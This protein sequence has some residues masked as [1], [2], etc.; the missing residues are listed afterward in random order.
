MNTVKRN[1]HKW[2]TVPPGWKSRWYQTISLTLTLAVVVMLAN[3]ALPQP[4]SASSA[5]TN[6]GA[7]LLQFT[8]AGQVLGFSDDS[9]IVASTS[10]ML[11][12]DFLNSNVITPKADNAASGESITGKASAL[13]S[14]TYQ[15]LWDGVTV[16][17]EA[18]GT[19]IAKSTYY[20]E[21]ESQVDSIRLGY[22]HPV[23]IDKNGNLS[24]DY[25]DGTIVE[26]TPVAWQEIDGKKKPVTAS[27]VL[28]GE[29]E[30]GFSLADYVPGIAM[31]IDP[32][33]SWNTF[34]GGSGEGDCDDNG[35]AIA[36][37]SS[38]NVYVAGYS[39]ESW[40]TPVRAFSGGSYD[41]F[42]A[43]L[44][45]SGNLLWNTFLGSNGAD[46]VFSIAVDS[47]GS[48]VYA[49]GESNATWGLP[50]RS[51]TTEGSHDED[52]FAAKLNAGNGSLSWNTFLGV[53]VALADYNGEYDMVQYFCGIAL[54][55]SGNVYISGNSDATWQGSSPPVRAYISGDGEDIFAAK[56]DSSGSLQ[57]NT[58]LGGTGTDRSSTIAID[59]SGNVYVAGNSDA[60]WGSPM[61]V[62]SDGTDVFAAKLN[63][64]GVLQWNTFLGSGS[65]WSG[66]IAV[67]GSGNIYVCGESDAAWGSP[68]LPF[69][70]DGYDET[71]VAQLSNSGTLTWN[72]FLGSG[73][74]GYASGIALDSSGN[75]YICGDTTATWGS[76]TRAFTTGTDENAGS[77]NAFAAKL[78]S[79]GSLI[80]NTFL[81]GGSL[82]FGSGI[83]ID[84]SGGHVYVAGSTGAEWAMD[85]DYSADATWGS[86]VRAYTP[87]PYMQ[88]WSWD[89][90]AARVDSSGALTWNTFLGGPAIGNSNDDG[91]AIV[92]DSSGNV[93]VTGDSQASWGSPVRAYTSCGGVYDPADEG[94]DAFVAKLDSSG[95]LLWN[96]FLGGSGADHSQAIVLDGS[97]NIY[98]SGESN[99]TWGSPLRDYTPPT[100]TPDVGQTPV[101]DAFV[102]S[103]NSNGVLQWN[104]FLGGSGW[105]EGNAIALDSSGNIYVA[106]NSTATWQGSS[107]P[108]YAYSGSGSPAPD[109]AFVAKL[110]S[111]GNLTWNTFIPGDNSNGYLPGSISYA[112]AVDGSG[113][114][115]YIAGSSGAWGSPVRAYGGGGSDVFVAKLSG[116]NGART[117]NTFLGGTAADLCY[118]GIAVDGSGNIYVG[119][120]SNVTWGSPVRAFTTNNY[121][122]DAFVAKLS[123]SG[124]LTWNTFLGGSDSDQLSALVLDGSGNN[125]YAVGTSRATWGSPVQP[126]T[127]GPG[128][129]AKLNS[130]SGDLTWNTFPGGSDVHG[131]ALDSS[132]NIYITGTSYATWGTP[133][134]AFTTGSDAYVAKLDYH[135]PPTA[136]ITYS[137]TGPVKAGTSLTI[138]ATFSSAMGDNPVPQIAISGNN[139]LTATA[140]TKTDSTHYIYTYTVGTGDGTDT[141]ALSTGTDLAGNVVT[142]APTSGAN[143]TVDNTPPTAAITYSPNHSVNAGTSLLITA[144]FSQAMGDS[145]VPQIAISGNNTLTATAMTKT[146]ST[147]YTY[148]YTVGT[149]DGTDT[150]A[151]STGTDLANNVVTS[152]PTSGANFTVD[153]TPPAAAITYSLNHPVNAGTS[154]LITATFS[155][156]MGDSPVPQI[157][158]S[159]NN[160]LTATAMTKTDSTHYTYTYTAG[161]GDGTDTVALSTGTDLAGNVVTSAPTSG[162][163]FTV[164]NTPPTNENNVFHSNIN[165]NGG[166]AVTI[167]SSGDAT[168]SV[169]F[170]P[171]NTHTFIANGNMTAAGGTA[172]TILTPATD[173]VYKLY[174]IDAAGN[175]SIAST[176]TL[177]VDNIPPSISISAPSVSYVKSGQQVTY[178]IT[179]YDLNFYMCSLAV[180]NITLNTTGTAAGSKAVT[181]SGNSST[182]TTRTVTISNITGNG[183][184]GISIAMGTAAD[185]ANNR[186]P[187]V[188]P[189]ATFTVDNIAPTN[190]DTVFASSASVTHGTPVTI[191]SSASSGGAATDSVWFAPSGTS[192]FTAGPTMT[193]AGGTATS[194]QAPATPDTYNLFIIDAA[195]NV[196]AASTATLTV[197]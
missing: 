8:S 187:A 71:F 195:G 124:T 84:N 6:D 68:V 91:N 184:I 15:N 56:L 33:M 137:P 23:Q 48:N 30:I 166:V 121:L 111:S 145:P 120:N 85:Y 22:N 138:T 119:G 73:G 95:T 178:T 43:K 180:G 42:V 118:G 80:W 140:M 13:G 67:D 142:S 55:G 92:V 156:A 172:T 146:D 47:S 162:T 143:F 9:V 27:Y 175:Y 1:W 154:L 173:D 20:V 35:Y 108:T 155:Q 94:Y 105:D 130:S 87:T 28:Y 51:F 31:V 153:N 58:F 122:S 106:G 37:D 39:S 16:V 65:D 70:P 164:D 144:T 167:T 60:T 76:P 46:I 126:F 79:N 77:D 99:V 18:S 11:K 185:I 113:N 149:G 134:L 151:L 131:I 5:S 75:V 63:S 179:Y 64:S 147:H 102:A 139:T 25:K 196:S 24:I 69:T 114:N 89:T 81:G 83:A 190:Q 192:S 17:Y 186:A 86:P 174:V 107:P 158:I 45:S 26:S 100:Y 90:F 97:G 123:S 161:T 132:G 129:A 110:T 103:L 59:G 115:V 66:G 152:A 160:T 168:N 128:F 157:A 148:T 54:D 88:T 2:F 136:A 135:T 117:W 62:F 141:V 127:S 197:Q 49:S 112:I 133:V 150:V 194:I 98:I 52:A 29:R 109:N 7:N 74:Q 32:V 72:T 82:S 61:R 10:H 12:I 57:W 125:V 189:S 177:T 41:G 96:T 104:T 38:G 116:S 188:G 181:G 44:D 3:F 78:T 14:V 170:A 159:G 21:D 36:V 50:L 182:G 34:L 176:A 101:Y 183:T 163:N 93:Y 165:K 171:P 19:S 169:W 40:G 53:N 193:T 191:V 4:V